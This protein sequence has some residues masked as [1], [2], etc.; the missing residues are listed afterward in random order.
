[1]VKDVKL[2]F[3][4]PPVSRITPGTCQR[5]LRILGT[6]APGRESHCMRRRGA[7]T[8]RYS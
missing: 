2:A 5:C 3:P 8:P 6:P 4:V 7:A 1:M